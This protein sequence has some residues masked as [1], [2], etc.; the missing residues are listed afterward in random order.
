MLTKQQQTI[1]EQASKKA[2]GKLEFQQKKSS[3]KATG[4]QWKPFI[5][6]SG[7]YYTL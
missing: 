7:H 2:G 3:S 5:V 1:I 6:I 4:L